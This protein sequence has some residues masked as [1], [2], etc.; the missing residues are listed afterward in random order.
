MLMR[1]VT[2]EEGHSVCS[3]SQIIAYKTISSVPLPQ[4]SLEINIADE[5]FGESISL[6][7]W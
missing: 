7:Y 1:F 4:I 6:F 2:T 3:T 5:I